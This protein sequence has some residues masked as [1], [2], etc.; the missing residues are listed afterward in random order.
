MNKSF[1]R[2]ILYSV[3]RY[4]IMV[5]IFVFINLHFIGAVPSLNS[6]TISGVF[7]NGT[8]YIFSPNDDGTYDEAIILLTS[9]EIVNWSTMHV[10][11]ST[12]DKVKTFNKKDNSINNS[13][14][15]AGGFTDTIPPYVPDGFYR[16]NFSMTN[17]TNI[18]NTT[19]INLIFVDNTR[20]TFSNY[21]SSIA[22]SSQNT[23]VN[24]TII[25]INLQKV[26]LEFNN[27]NYTVTSNNSGVF[28]FVILNGNYSANQ[29][30][31]YSWYANDSVGNFNKSL[32]RSFTILP[33]ATGQTTNN[34]NEENSSNRS[35]AESSG[36]SNKKGEVTRY[37]SD[38]QNKATESGE[39]IFSIKL[40][41]KS[42]LSKEE[43]SFTIFMGVTS[44]TLLTTLLL[45]LKNYF[46]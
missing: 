28:F 4:I 12:E 7:Y 18:T 35:F 16:L 15:W 25:E 34:T 14:V 13:K 5:F 9:S 42:E 46:L 39:E 8:D 40:N 32:Q 38:F 19:I 21:N 23:T 20:P 31:N 11:N 27:T 2:Q 10:I 30:I 45:L 41:S 44:L 3:I 1:K 6:S 17:Q 37:V 24:V 43:D 29:T 36:S 22:N 26:I 33:N